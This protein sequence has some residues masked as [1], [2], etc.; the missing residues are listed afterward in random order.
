LHDIEHG[1]WCGIPASALEANPSR[2][3]ACFVGS[4]AT[5][6]AELYYSSCARIDQHNSCRQDDLQLERK[7]ATTSWSMRVNMTHLGIVIVDSWLLCL[8]DRG[9][10]AGSQSDF[11]EELATDLVFNKYDSVGLRRRES[12][13][14]ESDTV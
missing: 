13:S 1:G 8:G 4:A 10:I 2:G 12:E 7:Y 5:E 6:A 3:I 9:A 11:Y 14:L